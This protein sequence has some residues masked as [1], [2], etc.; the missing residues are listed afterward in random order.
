MLFYKSYRKQSD[1]ELMRLLQQGEE[2]ALVELY[3]R[4]D[5]KLLRYFH[6]MLWRNE[7]RA[8]DFLQDL[9]IKVIEQPHLFNS[10]R[11][12]STWLYSVAHNMC[13]NEYRKQKLR[14]S[15][16][17]NRVDPSYI[18]LIPEAMDGV[19]FKVAL[20]EALNLFDEDDKTTFVLR[21]EMELSVK[22]IAAVMN[23]PEGSVKSKLFYLRKN[24]S[25][26]LV[27]FNPLQSKVL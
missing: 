5:K 19:K 4:Y 6:R 21:Y 27:I 11:K 8:Q 7:A 1:E 14:P 23:C 20:E 15:V 3:G 26:R 24:L 10:D 25:E 16:E 18:Q 12:F 13:K 17:Q 2:Q 9:F 22:E